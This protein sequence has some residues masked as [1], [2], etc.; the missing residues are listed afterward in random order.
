MFNIINYNFSHPFYLVSTNFIAFI[1]FAFFLITKT[2]E[3]WISYV[4]HLVN[5]LAFRNLTGLISWDKINTNIFKNNFCLC[6]S[7]ISTFPYDIQLGLEECPSYL[8]K[9]KS[10]YSSQRF[11]SRAW[12]KPLHYL[13]FSPQ[14]KQCQLWG[15][16]QA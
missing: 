7:N 1:I 6:I 16:Y 10:Q 3:K 5:Y 12:R 15:P 8:K 9:K 2:N 4:K 11:S 14:K 13:P